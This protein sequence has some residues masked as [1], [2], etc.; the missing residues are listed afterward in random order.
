MASQ[1][2]WIIPGYIGLGK[3]YLLRISAKKRYR[4]WN[5]LNPAGDLRVEAQ[6]GTQIDRD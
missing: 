1:G 3:F 5:N 2:K 6:D 4:I